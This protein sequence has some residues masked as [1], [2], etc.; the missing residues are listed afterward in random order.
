[1]LQAVSKMLHELVGFGRGFANRNDQILSLC[2]LEGTL[3]FSLGFFLFSSFAFGL[4]NGHREQGC[5]VARL[6]HFSIQLLN[7]FFAL[8]SPLA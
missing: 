3:N 1:M 8:G 7:L 5:F 4:L 2:H 6:G